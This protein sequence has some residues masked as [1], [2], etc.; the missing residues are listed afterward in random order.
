VLL[1]HLA[2]VAI[3]RVEQAAGAVLV[4]AHARVR[5]VACYTCGHA[6]SRVHSRYDRRLADAAISGQMVVLRL[7]VRRFFCDTTECGVHTFAEQPVG[8]ATPR[9]RRTPRSREMLESIGLA[10]AG[11]AGARLAT[12]LGMPAGRNTL[13]RLVR[14]LPDAPVGEVTVLGVDDFAIKKG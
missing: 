4:W 3:E 14:A 12:G 2:A 10:L 13:L 9:A 1:P 5:E 6:A 8:V 7:R 11:R